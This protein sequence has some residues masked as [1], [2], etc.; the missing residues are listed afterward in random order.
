[1]AAVVVCDAM[2]Y[3]DV[4]EIVAELGAERGLVGLV[5]SVVKV[6]DVWFKEFG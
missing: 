6:D 3:F 5:G 1:M 4:V 2:E